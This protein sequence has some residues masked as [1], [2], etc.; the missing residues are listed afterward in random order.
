MT[1]WTLG[2]SLLDPL[3]RDSGG[4]QRA[5][6][7][8]D[9]REKIVVDFALSDCVV[10]RDRG[11]VISQFSRRDVEIVHVLRNVYNYNIG[12]SYLRPKTI[13]SR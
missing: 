4:R 5:E 11:I 6:H 8:N 10:N 12:N 1:L 13:V 9:E 2:P 7:K 3:E